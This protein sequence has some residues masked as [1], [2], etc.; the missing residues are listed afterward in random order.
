LAGACDFWADVPYVVFILLVS[1]GAKVRRFDVAWDDLDGILPEPGFIRDWAYAGNLSSYWK[2]GR[3]VDEFNLSG[4]HSAQDEGHSVYFGSPK[5]AAQLTIYNKA[6][7]RRSKGEE[8]DGSWIRAELQCRRDRAH[9]IAKVFA[10]FCQDVE[11]TAQ[12]L[13]GILRQ[14]IEFKEPVATDSNRRRWPIVS[15]WSS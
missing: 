1:F 15:W 7:E 12:K 14:Y 6:A 10:E 5:S 9:A 4:D 11:G 13:A 8:F 2:K 3:R